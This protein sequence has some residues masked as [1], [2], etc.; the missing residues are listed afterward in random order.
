[1]LRTVLLPAIPTALALAAAE[2]QI[3][4]TN[5]ADLIIFPNG[6]QIYFAVGSG[7]GQGSASLVYSGPADFFGL[8]VFAPNYSDADPSV[9]AYNLNQMAEA[10]YRS[11]NLASGTSIDSNSNF[12]YTSAI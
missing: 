6:N 1:M 9:F 11:A 4:Y 7:G 3:I 2:G 5:P 8:R 12:V 10:N